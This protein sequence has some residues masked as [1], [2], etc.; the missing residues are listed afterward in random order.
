LT[1]VTE[2]IPEVVRFVEG[3]IRNGFA[4]E[5]GGSVYF[6]VLSYQKS[7]HAYAKLSPSSFGNVKLIEEGEGSLATGAGGK[8]NAV[9]FALWK[10]SKPGEPF[11][12][13]PWGQGRPGWHIECSAMA[14]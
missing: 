6:D 11:W 1:R 4:Y 2:Y 7:G 3:I 8:K 9:D 13:S 10:K 12:D 14:G 5:S